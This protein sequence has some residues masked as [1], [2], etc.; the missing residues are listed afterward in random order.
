MWPGQVAAGGIGKERRAGK[1]REQRGVEREE[2]GGKQGEMGKGGEGRRGERREREHER[3]ER[4]RGLN[5]PS[6]RGA[7]A[8]QGLAEGPDWRA[9]PAAA[10]A[11]ARQAELHEAAKRRELE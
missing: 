9:S 7:V 3:R 4:E 6:E 2:R 1:G 10:A 8:R 5:F 11:P